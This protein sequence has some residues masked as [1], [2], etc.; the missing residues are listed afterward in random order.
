MFLNF[1]N[2]QFAVFEVYKQFEYLHTH[3]YIMNI[4][5]KNYLDS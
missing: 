5:F 1:D 3:C 4:Q 2:L